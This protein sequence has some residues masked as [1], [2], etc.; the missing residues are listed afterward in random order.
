MVSSH[1]FE[2]FGEDTDARINHMHDRALWA[3]YKDEMILF[4][5]L[6]QKDRSGTT[7]Q[8]NIKDTVMQIEKA[9]INDSF[10]VSKVSWKFRISTIYNFAVIYPWNLQFSEKVG[11]FLT[12]SIVFSVYNQNFPAQ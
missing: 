4:L 2:C 11:Y 10:H 6:L 8:I 1:L 3:V 12:V 5:E 9:L 7:H